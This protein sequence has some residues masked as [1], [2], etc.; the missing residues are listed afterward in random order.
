M[1]SAWHRLLLIFPLLVAFVA[2]PRGVPVAAQEPSHVG[3]PSLSGTWLPVDGDFADKVFNIGLT[4]IPSGTK[5][6]IDQQPTR[7]TITIALP[8]DKLSAIS[9][10]T[11]R[12][13]TTVTY[14]PAEGRVGGYGAGGAP[15]V[16]HPT[17]LGDRF[18]VPDALPGG[19]R[20]MSYSL[21]GGLLQV[22][23][24]NQNPPWQTANT[25]TQLLKKIG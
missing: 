22:E 14:W 6:T 18:V 25:V 21:K 24:E 5:V 15:Q 1:S 23:S 7:I 20:M 8:D 2:V 19:G 12:F 13:Y 4:A 11:G 17:W 16:T 10:M 9:R 3:R